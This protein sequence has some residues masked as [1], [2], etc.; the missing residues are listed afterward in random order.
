MSIHEEVSQS[1]RKIVSESG[2]IVSPSMVA[3]TCYMLFG[4][5]QTDAHVRYGAV[6]HYKAMARKMLAARFEPDSEDNPVYQDDMFSGLLQEKYPKKRSPGEEPF[7]VPLLKLTVEDMEW[8]IA[9][10]EKGSVALAKHAI[11]FRAFRDN[12]NARRA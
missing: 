4:N 12:L 5:E 6:E 11:A 7:Y 9:R 8:N 2:D 1:I 10:L 3:N